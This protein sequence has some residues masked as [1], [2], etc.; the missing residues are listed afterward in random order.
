MIVGTKQ[1]ALILS[2][3]AIVVFTYGWHWWGGQSKQSPRDGVGG[4]G[5]QAGI[6]EIDTE[7]GRRDS[8]NSQSA[9]VTLKDKVLNAADD[10]EALVKLASKL[11]KNAD[12]EMLNVYRVQLKNFNPKQLAELMGAHY[13]TEEIVVSY[14]KSRESP[15]LLQAVFAA[16]PKVSESRGHLAAE[17]GEHMVFF[18]PKNIA[19]ALKMI[20]SDCLEE[21]GDGLANRVKLM[22]TEE[23]RMRAIEDYLSA[24]DS[25]PV[26]NRL[27]AMW[28]EKKALDDPAAAAEWLLQQKPEYISL[29]DSVVI[30]ALVSKAPETAA[31]FVNTLLERNEGKRA[32]YAVTSMVTA[33]A[34]SDPVGVLRW[35]EGLPRELPEYQTIVSR[36]FRFVASRNPEMVDDIISSTTDPVLLQTYEAIVKSK[37]KE[38]NHASSGKK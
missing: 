8:R 36:S 1:G 25:S 3:L 17:A 7:N 16:L 13:A 15:D 21:F 37:S 20:P 12:V 19:E 22:A 38:G 35:V 4:S 10:P 11:P 31:D 33:L 26:R 30:K 5:T 24:T 27:Q 2:A 32:T 23:E 18:A 14:V 29:S 28:I 34:P 9:K 6:G